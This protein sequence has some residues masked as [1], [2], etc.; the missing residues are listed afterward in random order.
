MIKSR[1]DFDVNESNPSEVSTHGLG[2]FD[3]EPHNSDDI[4]VCGPANE[5]LFSVLRLATTGVERSVL[6]GVLIAKK[7]IGF[8]FLMCPGSFRWKIG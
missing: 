8:F 2:N 6:L 1:S 7:N 5:Y 4:E 3:E